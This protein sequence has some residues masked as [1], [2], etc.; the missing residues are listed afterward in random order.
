MSTAN[1][2]RRPVVVHVGVAVGAALVV[3]AVLS[4]TGHPLRPAWFVAV[5]LTSAAISL[6]WRELGRRVTET[7]WPQRD[8]ESPAP[9]G[10]ETRVQFVSTWLQ[11]STRNREVYQRRIRPLL[12]TIVASRLRHAHRID[13]DF[14]PAAARAVTGEWLWDLVTGTQDRVLTYDELTRLVEEIEGL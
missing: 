7:R 4:A 1:A 12:V 2:V 5:A 10:S 9:R 3:V 13:L 14:E 11:E 6:A 8:D